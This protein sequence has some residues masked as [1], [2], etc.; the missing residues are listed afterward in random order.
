MAFEQA[1]GGVV[2]TVTF[3]TPVDVFQSVLQVP[4]FA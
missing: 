4:S 1:V 2:S 3:Q